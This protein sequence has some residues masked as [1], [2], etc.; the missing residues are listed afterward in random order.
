MISTG[1]AR[2][3]ERRTG[4]APRRSLGERRAIGRRGT[5]VGFVRAI[6]A[7]LAAFFR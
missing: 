3:R 2:T 6:G 5:R 1:F 4:P 7:G